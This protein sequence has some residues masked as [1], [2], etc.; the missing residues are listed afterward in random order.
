MCYTGKGRLEDS[1]G[2][3]KVYHHRW[4][5]FEK[6]I[7]VPKCVVCQG[8]PFDVSESKVKEGLYTEKDLEVFAKKAKDLGIVM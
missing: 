4:D 2:S 1:M 3:C 6:E 8:Y 5:E 7:G